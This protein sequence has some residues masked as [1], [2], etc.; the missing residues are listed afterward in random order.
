MSRDDLFFRELLR[1][2]SESDLKDGKKKEVV[3]KLQCG[4]RIVVQI[5]IEDKT[6][7]KV[8]KGD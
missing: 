1:Q 3:I 8:I 4:S 2:I 7:L 6:K 5:K